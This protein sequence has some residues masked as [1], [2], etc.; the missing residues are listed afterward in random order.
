MDGI[1]IL[2]QSRVACAVPGVELHQSAVGLFAQGVGRQPVAARFD[3]FVQFAGLCVGLDEPGESRS[4]RAAQVLGRRQLPVVEGDAV[5]QGEAAQEV[6]AIKRHRGRHLWQ[7]IGAGRGGVGMMVDLADERLK[8]CG[9]APTF[10]LD[11]A[12]AVARDVDR[13]IPNGRPQRGERPAQRGAGALVV[14]FR[15][16]QGGQRIARLKF[17]ADGQIG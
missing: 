13:A 12:Q 9:V 5:A 4:V 11:D 16:Q 1:A 8:S 15:P 10:V 6:I 14:H 17:A 2:A 7:T 3:S